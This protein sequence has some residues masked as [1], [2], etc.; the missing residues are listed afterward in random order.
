MNSQKNL[1]RIIL[2]FFGKIQVTDIKISSVKSFPLFCILEHFHNKLTK[3]KYSFT[4]TFLVYISF[5]KQN[6]DIPSSQYLLM[7]TLEVAT[8]E[9]ETNAFFVNRETYVQPLG[10]VCEETFNISGILVTSQQLSA[11]QLHIPGTQKTVISRVF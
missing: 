11:C 6:V 5:F 8:S 3:L 4:C 2:K 10:S 1:Y 9:V 7:N